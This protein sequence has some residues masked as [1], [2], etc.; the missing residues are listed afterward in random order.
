MAEYLST[1]E[2]QALKFPC[3]AV[4]NENGRRRVVLVTGEDLLDRYREQHDLKD[5]AVRFNNPSQLVRYLEMRSPPMKFVVCDPI[6]GGDVATH[7][8]E[9]LLRQYYMH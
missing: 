9:T 7:E 1:G 5:E 2:G 4:A 3:F 8:V 6:D